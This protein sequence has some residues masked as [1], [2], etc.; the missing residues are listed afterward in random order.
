MR[1]LLQ[2]VEGSVMNL[3]LLAGTY[4]RNTDAQNTRKILVMYGLLCRGLMVKQN[5][6]IGQTAPSPLD[7]SDL[8][9]EEILVGRAA[10][11][12]CF[13]FLFFLF[14]VFSGEGGR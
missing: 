8:V 10:V 4:I 9:N 6:Q 3:A 5:A 12:T 11:F 7:V 14:D 13:L 1:V 2:K